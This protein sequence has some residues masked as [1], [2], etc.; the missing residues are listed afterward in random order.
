MSNQ[1]IINQATYQFHGGIHPPEFKTLSSLSAISS[2]PLVDELIIPLQQSIG[3]AA[4]P[5]VSVGEQVS[6]G[7][8][9]AQMN[10]AISANIHSPANAIIEAI[11]PR[12][13]GHPSG[14]QLLVMVLAVIN[15][16]EQTTSDSM[17]KTKTASPNNDDWRSL[18]PEIL[19]G[20]VS[21]GGVVGMGGAGFPTQVKLAGSNINTLLVNA[22]ECEPYISCDDR[23]MREHA[24]KLLVGAQIA[25]T[26]VKAENIIF[27][28]EDNKP[29]SIDALEQAIVAL[30]QFDINSRFR[31]HISILVT[32]T[33][34]PS[35]GE[36][37]LIEIVT[38]QQVSKGQLPASLGLVIQNV[39]TLNAVYDAVVLHQPL[40]HRLV[41]ITGD[42][43]N[44]PGNYWIPLGTPIAAIMNY[45]AVQ[46]TDC[47]QVIIGGPLMGQKVKN[48][49][50]PVVKSTNCLIF[51]SN[52]ID[53]DVW[54]HEQ[55]AFKEC[56]RCS[57][58][59]QACPASL[60][61]QQLYWQSQSDQWDKLQAQGLFDCIE[62]GACAYVC[63]SEIPLVQYFRYAKS[64][65]RHNKLKAE[66]AEK[67]KQR[68]DFR[69]MR[70]LR[71]K[72]EKA[73]KHKQAAEARRLAAENPQEDPSG[74]K[75]A[76]AD[77]LARVKQKKQAASL[78]SNETPI[79]AELTAENNACPSKAAP[80]P[81]R[82][83]SK[84]ES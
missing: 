67:A 49:R 71:A 23:F 11:E 7:Q 54:T 40:T 8:L 43:P 52:Q 82:P 80:Q 12:F 37:Q 63:P 53:N 57:N 77:A 27:A 18:S 84:S 78:D 28:T 2:F 55:A 51:N 10:G 48:Y 34:Y 83:S 19:L 1:K 68:F 26:I 30:N 45:F 24:E 29:D 15:P 58:C 62:C 64:S 9:L 75:Q 60:L 74:K 44:Q 46:P 6:K 81:E 36:K 31:H 16:A 50:V 17:N 5:V 73:L 35:G 70:L 61:P 22:M 14:Q 39:A 66:K 41:T 21:D 69:E 33:K 25:A 3:A 4:R 56:I 20:R 72:E 38:G 76:I 32:P 42:L 13:T 47:A 65:I 79:Q 59:E